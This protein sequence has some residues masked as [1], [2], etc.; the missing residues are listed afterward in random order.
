[1]WQYLG[2][3][4]LGIAFKRQVAI[5]QFIVD[6]LS[7]SIGLDGE[8]HQRRIAADERRDCKL[9]HIGYRTLRLDAAL[10]MRE[11]QVALETG[12]KGRRRW[13]TDSRGFQRSKDAH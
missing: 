4:R 8:W 11:P 9:T 1:M 5:D 7:P 10:V 12:Q 3:K 2:G 13:G 6:F